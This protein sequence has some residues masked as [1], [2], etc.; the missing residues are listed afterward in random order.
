V[1]RVGRRL[2]KKVNKF[3][4][5]IFE[6]G[7]SSRENPNPVANAEEE[8]GL[9]S[10]WVWPNQKFADK[11]EDNRSGGRKLPSFWMKPSADGV[12]RR[13]RAKKSGRGAIAD[14]APVFFDVKHGTG[15][16]GGPRPKVLAA[17]FRRKHCWRTI[18]AVLRMFAKY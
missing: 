11:I 16:N 12:G 14:R 3:K 7:P 18:L 1:A 6:R 9:V 13:L 4:A 5:E 17:C 15:L 2:L 10:T 8:L